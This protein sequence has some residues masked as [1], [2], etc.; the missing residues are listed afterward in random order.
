CWTRSRKRKDERNER[1]TFVIGTAVGGAPR[2]DAGSFPL[3]GRLDCGPVP[4]APQINGPRIESERAL[5]VG[6][7]RAG[8]DGGG[9]DRDLCPAGTIGADTAQS[10]A[11]R[12]SF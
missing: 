12:C 7:R 3:A 2:L 6:L 10:T 1:G 8:D 11:G 4:C 5:R 9:S